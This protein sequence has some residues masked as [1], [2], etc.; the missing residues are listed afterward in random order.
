[1]AA[2]GPSG[3][4]SRFD[5]GQNAEINVTPFVDVMLVLLIIFMVAAPLP[6]VSIKIEIPPAIDQP[7]KPPKPPVFISVM[8]MG[9]L[10]I[11]DQPTT[12]DTLITDVTAALASPNPTN[13]RIMIRANRDVPYKEFMAVL[14][15][16]QGSGFVKI[17]L[18][19]EDL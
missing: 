4:K 15:L 5:L 14:N 11:A 13:E 2:S 1:M 12:M 16:L 10:A 19:A 7:V 9:K 17:G 8:G 18:I 6:T 3:K